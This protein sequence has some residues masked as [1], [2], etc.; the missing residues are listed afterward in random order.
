MKLLFSTQACSLS[1]L[2]QESKFKA[3]ANILT[4]HQLKKAML[5]N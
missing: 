4:I 2:T 5:V 1:A 3:S